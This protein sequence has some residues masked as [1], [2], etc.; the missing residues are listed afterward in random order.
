MVAELSAAFACA[1]LGVVPTV[2]HADYLGAWLAILKE[3]NRAIFRA[4][5]RAS[6]AADYLLAFAPDRAGEGMDPLASTPAK[7]GLS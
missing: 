1:A 5:S 4:A 2:R 7:D 6:K 3:D